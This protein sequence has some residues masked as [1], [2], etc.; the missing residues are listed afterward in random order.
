MKTPQILPYHYVLIPRLNSEDKYKFESVRLANALAGIKSDT[1]FFDVMD[2][3]S[4]YSKFI[5][6]IV[7]PE[8]L[9]NEKHFM[10]VS[11]AL[12]LKPGTILF[13]SNYDMNDTF[14]IIEKLCEFREDSKFLLAVYEE[15]HDAWGLIDRPQNLDVCIHRGEVTKTLMQKLGMTG[16]SQC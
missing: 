10:E 11:N 16:F 9:R 5:S 6:Q 3:E 15:Q 13:I 1:V 7:C 14:F 12:F 2:F 8:K 4:R